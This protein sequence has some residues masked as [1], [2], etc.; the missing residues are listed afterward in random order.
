VN[1]R[2]EGT[3][4]YSG[5]LKGGNLASFDFINAFSVQDSA[6]G[7]TNIYD[8][9]GGEYFLK[10]TTGPTPNCPWSVVFTPID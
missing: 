8:L 4:Y 5:D 10:V 6:E 9:A 2:T 3:C 1:W 7:T